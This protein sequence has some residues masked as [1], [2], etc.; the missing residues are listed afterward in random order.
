M[1]TP[2]PSPGPGAHRFGH[3]VVA[4]VCRHMNDDHRDDALLICRTLGGQPGATE[5]SAVHVDGVSIHF[6]ATVDGT[7]APVR[8]PF[9]EPVTERPQIR[10]AVVEV[11]E[12]ACAAA[13]VLPRD[14]GH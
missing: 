14:A 2:D 7:P 9:A 11:Y 12:R 1:S 6:T 5:A 3:D 4:A 8:V 10:S 13:G